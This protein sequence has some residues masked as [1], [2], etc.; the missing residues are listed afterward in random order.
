MWLIIQPSNFL[1]LLLII[2]LLLIIFG[3]KPKLGKKII[4]STLI[5]LFF[6]GFSNIGSWLLFPLEGRFSIYT[7]QTTLGPYQGIIVL[8]GSEQYDISTAHN[9]VSLNH[10][11]DRLIAAA[12][13]SKKFPTLPVIHSGSGPKS[14]DQ[15]SET[16]VAKKF[17]EDM[18]L[19]LSKIRFDDKAYNTHTN[20][21][22]SKK[23]IK[24][25]END[26]WLLVTSAFHMPRSVGAFRNAGVKIQPY[27]VDYKTT[28]KYQGFFKLNVAKNLFLFD[29][30]IHEYIGLVSYYC[31]DRSSELF[32]AV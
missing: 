14:I 32:P 21:I 22:N 23:L 6:V 25:S 29:L 12:A 10:G 18:G 5:F 8:S 19:D 28:L 3:K 20:A 24:D 9:Q 27:P 1:F 13:L 26:P 11:A 31:T 4:L 17:F 7:N 16:D 30:A 2:G 15:W